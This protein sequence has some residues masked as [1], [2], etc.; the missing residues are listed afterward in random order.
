MS[1]AKTPARPTL[2][3]TEIDACTLK[4]QALEK[5]RL[6][7]GQRGGELIVEMG[8]LLIG[9][10]ASLHHGQWLLWAEAEL[11]FT[12]KTAERY[13]QVASNSTL[14]SNLLPL[15][16]TQLCI[17]AEIAGSHP[18]AVKGLTPETVINGTPLKEIDC[19][20]LKRALVPGT[21]P[22]KAPKPMATPVMTGQDCLQRLA[23]I[24]ESDPAAWKELA[25][26][27]E[28]LLK[29]ESKPAAPVEPATRDGRAQEA[30][31]AMSEAFDLVRRVGDAPG[32]LSPENKALLSSVVQRG[33][34]DVQKLPAF[35]PP[36]PA[37][38][39][40]GVG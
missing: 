31:A 16:P 30:F 37:E 24:K 11:P 13:M 36:K 15:E 28:T 34:R 32:K 6:A 17:L 18:E 22:K 4:I 2:T 26:A 19:C 29:D 33:W 8:R 3:P 21:A 38:E 7:L 25:A 23:A 35:A 39:I 9:I 1:R 27:L 20:D 5:Q 14:M 12:V 10:K 40:R